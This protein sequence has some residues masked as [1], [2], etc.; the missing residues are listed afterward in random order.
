MVYVKPLRFSKPLNPIPI[1]TK[2]KIKSGPTKLEL[3]V[4]YSIPANNNTGK[5]DHNRDLNTSGFNGLYIS[6]WFILFSNLQSKIFPIA[7]GTK[8]HNLNSPINLCRSSA[9][10]QEIITA[11]IYKPVLQAISNWI[12]L[13]P[14]S[15]YYQSGCSLFPWH[16]FPPLPHKYV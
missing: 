4:K 7:I 12:C 13:F 10:N 15:S 5:E 2:N 3:S 11:A 14:K 6:V 9:T 8:I 16:C 1:K